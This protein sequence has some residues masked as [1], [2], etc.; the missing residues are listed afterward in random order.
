[1][2]VLQNLLQNRAW[3]AAE[4][5]ALRS[6]RTALGAEVAG[7]VAPLLDYGKPDYEVPPSSP[8]DA[9]K[10]SVAN[11]AEAIA[12]ADR[13]VVKRDCTEALFALAVCQEATG[14]AEEALY[15]YRY[16]FR[17]SPD[18]ASAEGIARCHEALGAAARIA[19]QKHS[20]RKAG[21]RASLE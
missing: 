3:D 7:K 17:L 20:V 5:Y 6:V 21:R 12:A 4:K 8:S 15:T 9:E 16:V 13:L 2:L 19:E 11:E 1:M 14:R 10:V 18:A